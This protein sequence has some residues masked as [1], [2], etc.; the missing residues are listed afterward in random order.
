MKRIIYIL[1]AIMLASCG[2]NDDTAATTHEA[3]ELP[4]IDVQQVHLQTVPVTADYTATVEAFKT[5][6]ITTSATARIKEIRVDVGSVVSAG[7]PLV[8]LDDVNIAQTR[9]RLDDAERELRRAEELLRIGAGTVQ[10]VDRMRTERDA[11]KRQYDNL[12]ENTTLTSP[13]SGVVT[14]RNYDPGDLPGQQPILTVEQL[15]PVK[16]VVNM[17]EADFAKLRPGMDAAVRL[18]V[19]GDEEFAGKVHLIH[20]TID[21]A[22]RTFGVEV[23]VPNADGRVHPGMFARVTM[24]YGSA[25]RVVVPDRAVVKQTGSGNRYVYTL[26]PDSTVSYDRVELG[27]RIG[28]SYELV[29]GVDN[30]AWVVTSGQVRLNDGTRVEPRRKNASEN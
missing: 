14:A 4:L 1:P 16:I 3:E 24:D 12:V 13:I 8:I 2:G 9:V 25:E 20:P 27:R 21:P 5:N 22:T 17:N 7:Q 30:G 18:D 10:N 28:D 15:R 6:N 29:S 23:T 26:N 19:Y 11:L